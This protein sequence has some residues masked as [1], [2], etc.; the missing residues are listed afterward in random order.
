MKMMRISLLLLFCIVTII[1]V[2]VDAHSYSESI[3]TVNRNEQ[4]KN[5]YNI[6]ST[7]NFLSV[8]GGARAKLNLFSMLKAFWASLFNPANDELLDPAAKARKSG[9]KGKSKGRSL[10]D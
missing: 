4:Q 3:V 5:F 6:K 8:R 9:K 2:T 10:K 1:S 7:S